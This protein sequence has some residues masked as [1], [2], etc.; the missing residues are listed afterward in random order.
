M[1]DDNNNDD[2]L[3]RTRRSYSLAYKKAVVNLLITTSQAKVSA[4]TGV[5]LR[6]LQKWSA[7]LSQS[8]KAMPLTSR[9]MFGGGPPEIIP[10]PDVLHI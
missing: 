4:C 1:P 6:T 3:K 9:M 7:Q 8:E 5:L 10:N 2:S